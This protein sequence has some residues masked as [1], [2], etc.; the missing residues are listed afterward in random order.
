MLHKHKIKIALEMHYEETGISYTY[1]PNYIVFGKPC[2]I[3]KTKCFRIGN[4]NEIQDITSE[5]YCDSYFNY[6][7]KSSCIVA[8]KI[9]FGPLGSGEVRK[10][11][12][13][14]NIPVENIS[15]YSHKLVEG[16]AGAK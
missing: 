5:Q 11:G 15:P 13:Y 16:K 4:Q 6:K 3:L 10:M 2:M 14:F 1:K 9:A 7:K 8:R 12:I